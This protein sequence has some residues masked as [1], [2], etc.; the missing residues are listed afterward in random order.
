MREKQRGI[1]SS[2]TK[3]GANGSGIDIVSLLYL[4]V[5]TISIKDSEMVLIFSAV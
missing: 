5:V 4:A 3:K 1:S 2:S